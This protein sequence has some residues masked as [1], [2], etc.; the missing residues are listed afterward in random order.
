MDRKSRAP[1]YDPGLCIQEF[2][3]N[4]YILKIKQ[5]IMLHSASFKF[6]LN[7]FDS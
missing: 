5:I 7:F 6:F 1:K 4:I 3:L 2:K